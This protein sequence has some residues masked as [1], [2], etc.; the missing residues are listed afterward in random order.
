MVAYGVLVCGVEFNVEV[1]D[2][3]VAA[4]GVVVCGV[5][6]KLDVDFFFGS[7]WGGGLLDRL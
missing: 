5:D 3:C 7:I 2:L 1:D 4:Y 6:F